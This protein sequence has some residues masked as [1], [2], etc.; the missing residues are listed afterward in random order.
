M[1]SNMSLLKKMTH[2]EIAFKL[3]SLLRLKMA[4]HIMNIKIWIMMRL[5]F[6]FM[7]FQSPHIFGMKP[8]MKQSI[9]DLVLSD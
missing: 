2:F 4:I 1:I 9:G 8:I 5:W 6:L 3:E 7:D